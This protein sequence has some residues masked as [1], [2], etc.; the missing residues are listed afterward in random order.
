MG[1]MKT[2]ILIVEDS[3]TVS[4]QIEDTITGLGYESVGIAKSGEVAIEMAKA[5]SPDV[6]IMDMW[7]QG[8]LNGSETAAIITKTM[9]NPVIFLTSSADVSLLETLRHSRGTSYMVKPVNPVELQFNI[10]LSVIKAEHSRMLK[11]QKRWQEAILESVVD[12]VIAEDASGKINYINS[13]GR[14]LLEIK[15]DYIGKETSDYMTAYWKDSDEPVTDMP[16][17]KGNVECKIATHNGKH[18]NVIMKIAKIMT[19][20]GQY[21]GRAITLTNITEEAELQGRINFLTFHD[22]M[23]GLYNRNYL[24]EEIERLNTNR[25]LPISI[26]M[27]DL[28]GLKIVNDLMGHAEG[29]EIIR[30]SADVLRNATRSEDIVARV[31][32]DEFL[33]FLPN[34]DAEGAE[35]ISQRIMAACGRR[36]T[37]L[38]KL[39]MAIGHYTKYDP[40]EHIRLCITKADEDMYAKKS[41][42]KAKFYED[43]F[44]HLYRRMAEHPYEGMQVTTRVRDFMA[45][46]CLLDATTKAFVKEAVMLSEVYDIGMIC[47]NEGVY[48]NR[49]FNDNDKR[50]MRRH[51]ETGMRIAEMSHHYQK[52]AKLI[53]YHHHRYDGLGAND[54]IKGDL[55]PLLSRLLAVVDTFVALTGDRLYREPMSVKQASNEI[56]KGS[57]NQFDPWAVDLFFKALHKIGLE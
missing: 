32:G 18:F 22:S 8:E 49:I 39:S 13:P 25:Q 53:P 3:E 35:Q 38:G 15:D 17:T 57:G 52:V 43:C 36:A 12:G 7:L 54:G 23:T 55:I 46:M 51:C 45:E 27:A 42:M 56:A 10:E 9:D 33:I 11:N 44:N 2:R 28:N 6:I 48:T 14:Q 31:G 30:M 24:D 4:R 5:L 16:A 26:I 47:L 34:T 29:D 19:E 20:D 50:M 21:L 37:K 1:K 40:F 41:L